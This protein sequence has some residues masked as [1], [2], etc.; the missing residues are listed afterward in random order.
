MH[1]PFLFPSTLLDVVFG[2]G[3]SEPTAPLRWLLA[4]AVCV[5]AGAPFL[6]ALVAAGRSWAVAGITAGALLVN[7]AGNLYAIPTLGITGAAAATFASEISIL[8]CSLFL[9]LRRP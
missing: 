2:P 5:F 8:V 1:L 4:G 7:M 6:T 9:L 3:F